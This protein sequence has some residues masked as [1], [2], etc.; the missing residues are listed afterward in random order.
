VP[1]K[2]AKITS[3]INPK[4]L[5][6]RVKKEYMPDDLRIFILLLGG[7]SFQYYIG[8]EFE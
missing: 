1:K 2:L 5:L 6:M 8:F 4:I 3:L 7:L